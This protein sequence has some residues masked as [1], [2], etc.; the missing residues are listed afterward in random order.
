MSQ[1][2]EVDSSEGDAPLIFNAVVNC[3]LP[4]LHNH[5]CISSA[6][7]C[8]LSLST[9]YL[10]TAGKSAAEIYLLSESVNEYTDC[11]YD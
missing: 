1:S 10:R 6:D 9:T 2:A 11:K 5:N 3:I 8:L 7:G 4:Y